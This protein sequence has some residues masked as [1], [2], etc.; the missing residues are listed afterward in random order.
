VGVALAPEQGGIGRIFLIS[1]SSC[2]LLGDLNLPERDLYLRQGS[3]TSAVSS[4]LAE[5]E[6]EIIR[7][8]TQAGLRSARARGR[9]GGQPK[10]LTDRQVQMLRQ[11]AAD[12]DRSVEEICQTL[13][14]G[15]TTYYRYMKAEEAD[16][17]TR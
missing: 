11:L 13:G 9:S 2:S 8:R 1:R 3:R 10:A 15:R 5:F 4:E 6:Q 17:H 7:K 14:I 16:A 12:K